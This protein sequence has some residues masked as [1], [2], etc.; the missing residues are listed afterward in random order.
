M[1]QEVNQLLEGFS[2]L[3]NGVDVS[4]A[5]SGDRWL[6][7]ERSQFSEDGLFFTTGT[8]LL[9][10]DPLGAG[11]FAPNFFSPRSNFQQWKTGNAVVIEVRFD[12]TLERLF[13]GYIRNLPATP[14]SNSAELEIPICCELTYRNTESEAGDRAGVVLGTPKSRTDILVSIATQS[15]WVG[16]LAGAVISEY[17][18]DYPIPK[19]S[20]TYVQQMGAIAASAGYGLDCDR[21]GNL[22]ASKIELAPTVILERDNTNSFLSPVDGSEEPR[23]KVKAVVVGRDVS[24]NS[25]TDSF[26]IEEIGVVEYLGQTG[27]Y[28]TETY[29]RKRTTVTDA[30]SADY[31]TNT[32]T[33]KVEATLSEDGRRSLILKDITTETKE[34]SRQDDGKLMRRTKTILAG[35]YYAPQIGLIAGPDRTARVTN[36]DVESWTYA[37]ELPISQEITYYGLTLNKFNG[38]VTSIQDDTLLK[39]ERTEWQQ[40]QGDR[41]RKVVGTYTPTKVAGVVQ[42]I[43][44]STVYFGAQYAP[45]EPER[46]IPTDSSKEISYEG[47]AEFGGIVGAG[48][49]Q[50]LYEFEYGVSSAQAELLAR[51]HGA[52]LVGRHRSWQCSMPLTAEWLDWRPGSGAKIRLPDGAIVLFMIDGPSINLSAYE[53]VVTFNLIDMGTVG[54]QPYELPVGRIL[55]GSPATSVEPTPPTV[56]PLIPPYVPIYSGRFGDLNRFAGLIVVDDVQPAA[57][58]FRDRNRFAGLDPTGDSLARFGD[59]NRFAVDETVA[60]TPL[61]IA[62]GGTGASSAAGARNNLGLAIAGGDLTGS[63]P[64]PAIV[65]GAVTYEKFQEIPQGLLG[66]SRTDESVVEVVTI[67]DNLVLDEGVLSATGGTGGGSTVVFETTLISDAA[68][69]ALTGI[70]A[71]K[72]Y[73]LIFQGKLSTTSVILLNIN[74]DSSTA[75]YR[76]QYI[77][78]SSSTLIA[79]VDSTFAGLCI[80]YSVDNTIVFIDSSISTRMERFETISHVNRDDG[81]SI[82]ATF[83]AG[84]YSEPIDS[85]LTTSITLFAGLIKAGSSIRLIEK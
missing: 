67:G 13:T 72:N 25:L 12:G 20:G 33:T 73:Q 39:T 61:A 23:E 74:S 8:L 1:L 18:I 75:H 15:G 62:E 14:A 7:L 5:V 80:G 34:F 56:T 49:E 24:A 64:N 42:D 59:A 65:Q 10:P 77:F 55:D 26:V 36:R 82:G 66:N 70:E 22:R 37:G 76:T 81:G 29:I 78:G 48:G 4:S 71:N 83:R 84:R 60:P 52:V 11:P 40:Q 46:H 35:P 63:Y 28:D 2:V 54:Y 3:V 19:T 44:E 43:G 51:L 79:G 16:G 57:G 27:V 17:P 32:L 41:W 30:W 47:T 68:S 45:P 6:G 50:A 21:L 38:I 85:G 69:V 53:G 58:E 31:K 9:L